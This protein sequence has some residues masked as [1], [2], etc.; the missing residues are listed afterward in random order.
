[1]GLR[2]RRPYSSADGGSKMACGETPVY[3]F[4]VEGG[5]VFGAVVLTGHCWLQAVIDPLAPNL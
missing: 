2:I 1:M 4:L 5:D 3:Q